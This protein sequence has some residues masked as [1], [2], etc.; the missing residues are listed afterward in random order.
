MNGRSF[1]AVMF[2]LTLFTLIISIFPVNAWNY[3]DTGAEDTKYEEFGPRAD[4]LL[5]ELFPDA[6]A[7][8][9]ALE[10]GDIDITDW[11]LSEPYYDRFTTPPQNESIETK[12]YGAEFGMFLLD[13]NHN[14]NPFLGN[15]QDPA[16]PNPVYPN[17]PT[18]CVNMRQA[19]WHL[20]DRDTWGDTYIGKGFYHPLISTHPPNY[21]AYSKPMANPY[22]YSPAAAIAKLESDVCPAD[23]APDFPM[24][25]GTGY[26]YHDLN[27][28]GAYDAPD[29]YVEI[30]FAIRNDTYAY[31]R[32]SWGNALAAEMEAINIRVDARYGPPAV[33]YDWWFSNKE[34]HLYTAGWSFGVDPDYVVLWDSRY[35]WHPGFAYNTGYVNDAIIDD[36]ADHVQYADTLDEA[37]TYCYIFQDR[38]AEIAA[39]VPWWSPAGSKAV[40]RRYTGGTN[41]V[42]QGD[43]ED[44][45][46]GRYWDGIVNKPAYGCDDYYSFFNMH[47]RGFER[48]SGSDMTIRYAFKV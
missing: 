6:E 35:Y 45:Y 29:E 46:R 16:Y 44:P 11:P 7:E 47:P 17:N 5:I 12:Y 24:D 1:L 22:P 36:A 20:T 38:F 43:G 25:D 8:W 13:I 18:S 34:V 10:A 27:G 14:N 41:E 2:L 9:D 42:L 37:L 40:R 39:A 32:L 26:R 33:A 15:P 19:I 21:G 3:T 4:R 31:H 23:G 30:K 48:G 28:N